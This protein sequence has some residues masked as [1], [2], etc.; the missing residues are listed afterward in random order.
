VFLIANLLQLSARGQPQHKQRANYTQDLASTEDE[1]QTHPEKTGKTK[2][3]KSGE[4]K[5]TLSLFKILAHR[6]QSTHEYRV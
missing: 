4:V 6:Q 5:V 1:K 3:Q 2:T